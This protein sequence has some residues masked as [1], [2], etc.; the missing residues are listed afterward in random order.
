MVAVAQRYGARPVVHSCRRSTHILRDLAAMPGLL[1]A[2]LGDATDLGLA[3]QLMP[4]VGIY[5]VPD[6]V[7]W[8]RQLAADT[9]NSV[10]SIMNAA[11]SG[12]LAFQFVM[13][14]GLRP[15]TIQAVL[16]AVRGFNAAL[17]ET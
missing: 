15:E 10:R 7:A 16:G 2:H 3:R 6:S 4:E 14:A 13:E 1:E 9:V 11:G 17:E 5:V 8:A 12:P